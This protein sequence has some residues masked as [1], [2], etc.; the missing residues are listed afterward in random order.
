MQ[1]EKNYQ[2]SIFIFMIGK[3]QILSN[4]EMLDSRNSKKMQAQTYH[5]IKQMYM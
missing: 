4:P 1:K 3:S 2:Q 5:M